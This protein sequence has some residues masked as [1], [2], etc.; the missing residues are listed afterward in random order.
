MTYNSQTRNTDPELM[1]D[2]AL[3]PEILQEAVDDISK[4]NKL[5][6]GNKFT[7]DAVKEVI[8]QFPDQ[9]LTI[10]DAGCGDGEMLRYLHK[11][12]NDQRLNFLGVD[13]SAASIDEAR[14]RGEGFE[15]LRFRESDILKADDLHCDILLSTLTMHHF[16]DKEIVTFLKRY[17]EI[18][19]KYVII[20]DLH[21]HRL[22]YGFFKVLSPIFS[23]RKI[24]IHDGLI[25]IASGFK[26][27][28]FKKYARAAGIKNDR[29]KWKWSFRFIWMIPTY[30]R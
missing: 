30:E 7:L 28:D 13:F 18:A 20:N 24:S 23:L 17:K 4:V 11:K 15:G 14:K 27:S 21:R 9:E 10:V 19:S 22:A 5:L 26:K 16:S 29:L 12:L 8:A 25:S 3:E 6:G 1:D 2:P